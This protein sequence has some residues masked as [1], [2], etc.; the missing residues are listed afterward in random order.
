MLWWSR[1]PSSSV[2]LRL[3]REK[4]SLKLHFVHL[5]IDGAE[6]RTEIGQRWRNAK[7]LPDIS[8]NT[9]QMSGSVPCILSSL[10][11]FRPFSAPS[12]LKWN[13]VLESFSLVSVLFE[14]FLATFRI[15]DERVSC[16]ADEHFGVGRKNTFC[17]IAQNA[18]SSYTIAM[19]VL[20][21]ET[22]AL[23]STPHSYTYSYMQS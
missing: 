15:A 14:G 1:Y 3:L 10:P 19:N 5:R 4:V 18:F 8:K 2:L 7:R 9:Q 12:I 20:V 16:A 21:L 17:A 23:N 6:K 22:N 13:E 11:C